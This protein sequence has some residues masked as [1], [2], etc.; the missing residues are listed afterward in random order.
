VAAT[1]TLVQD[2]DCS[3]EGYKDF[4]KGIG[5]KITIGCCVLQFLLYKVITWVI[6]DYPDTARILSPKHSPHVSKNQGL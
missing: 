5:D 2:T 3:D 6:S 1:K 4:D